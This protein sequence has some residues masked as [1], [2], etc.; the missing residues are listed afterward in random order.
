MKV[1]TF[2]QF[3]KI[4]AVILFVFLGCES[5]ISEPA[6]PPVENHTP[7]IDSIDISDRFVFINQVTLLSCYA[8]DVDDDQLSYKWNAS[9]GRITN[10]T[11][12]NVNWKPEVRGNALLS[13][14]V[15]DGDTTIK[16]SISID[17]YE[18]RLIEN[19]LFTNQSII[20]RKIIPAPDGGFMILGG[21]SRFQERTTNIIKTDSDGNVQWS[22]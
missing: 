22:N 3:W 4:L 14:E 17:V 9:Q 7:I 2:A 18:F 16:D 12:Q 5:E 20:A 8:R 1:F 6:I 15:S 21:P 13:V 10:N 11:I 19:V